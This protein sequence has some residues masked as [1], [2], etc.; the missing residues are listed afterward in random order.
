MS[1]GING[2]DINTGRE[3][4]KEKVNGKTGTWYPVYH[5]WS[6]VPDKKRK[7]KRKK[8]VQRNSSSR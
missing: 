1:D 2:V 4:Y 8:N 3:A 5:G 7:T 6:F